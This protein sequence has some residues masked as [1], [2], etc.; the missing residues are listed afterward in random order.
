MT[1]E[2]L[3]DHD[4]R[5]E[6][7]LRE[8]ADGGIGLVLDG[9]GTGLSSLTHLRRFP[10]VG[11]AIESSFVARMMTDEPSAQL[12]LAMI[13]A[14]W[15]FDLPVTARGVETVDQKSVLARWGCQG[16]QGRL[17]A[18]PVSAVEAPG[19]S[20][21]T[22]TRCGSTRDP[23]CGRAGPSPARRPDQVVSA[24]REGDLEDR[25]DGIERGLWERR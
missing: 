18:R 23:C 8:L 25:Q 19:S 20:S 7:L 9:F 6:S 13:E 12:V 4:P 1:E 14:A 10:L 24:R 5:V 17:L 16:A 2:V 22:P 21:A 3:L 15:A 11:I